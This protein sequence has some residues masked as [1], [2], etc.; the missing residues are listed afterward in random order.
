MNTE[1]LHLDV[2]NVCLKLSDE[3]ILLHTN[4]NAQPHRH[5]HK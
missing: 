4:A 5:D 1:P 2:H 3:M